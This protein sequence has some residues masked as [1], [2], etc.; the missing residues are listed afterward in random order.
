M[1]G[2]L[3]A[4]V[5]VRASMAHLNLVK[6]HPWADG[7]GR[8]SRALSTLVF[9]REALMP[10]EFSSIEEWL[11]RG[12]N[13]YGY[14]QVLKETGGAAWSPQGDAHAWIRFCLRAHHLQAQQ[15]KRRVDLLSRAW[16]A[17]SE[18]AA[19]AGRDERVTFALLP[20]FWGSRV[21]RTIYQQDAELSDQQS[22]RDVREL[23]RLGWLVSHG[24]ARGRYYLAGPAMQPVLDTVKRSTTPFTEPYDQPT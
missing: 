2:D 5:A 4:P 8:M 15:A 12:Q 10:P 1:T 19:G 11:G 17:L 3:D 23:C 18:A 13:T 22:I 24:Q 16:I 21:R 20:A 7:N 9:S 6:I 14:Y